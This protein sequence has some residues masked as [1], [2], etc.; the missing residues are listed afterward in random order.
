MPEF[1]RV[2]G[3][4]LPTAP[5]PWDAA[6][7]FLYGRRMS[8]RNRLDIPPIAQLLAFESVARHRSFS[9]AAEA[10]ETSQPAI[11]RYVARLE[12]RLSARL[13]ERSPAGTRPTAAGEH[14]NAGISAG[15]DAI[16]RAILDARG[17][18]GEERTVIACSPDVWQF[19]LLPC[20]EALR[21]A[22]GA[23]TAVEVRL[24][25]DDPDADVAIGREE[26]GDAAEEM[27]LRETVRPV[28]APS[29]AAAHWDVL[30]GPVAGWGRLAFLDCAPQD[31]GWTTWDRW[32]AVAGLPSRAPCVRRLGSYLDV[33][34]AAAAGQGMALGR[35]HLVA[36]HLEAGVLIAVHREFTETGGDLRIA[37]TEKGRAKPPAHRCLAFF[38]ATLPD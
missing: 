29:Y 5:A 16:R 7:S 24:D 35:R 9:R 33:V 4:D 13:F 10:L 22:L 38:R 14:L 26:V 21:D 17:A 2:D 30:D 34:R 3:P 36:R 11:S 37:L 6:G 19:L 8:Q 15:L 28:C 32:F 27:T 1:D 12:A 20:I 23:D 31:P 18:A 25:R